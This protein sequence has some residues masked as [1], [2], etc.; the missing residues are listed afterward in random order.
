MC[1][2]EKGRALL[3]GETAGNKKGQV[4]ELLLGQDGMITIYLSLVFLLF[5]LWI[6]LILVVILLF[7][8]VLMV[9]F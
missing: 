2:M 3:D 4:V 5:L 9:L 7:Q 6:C 8:M 1:D